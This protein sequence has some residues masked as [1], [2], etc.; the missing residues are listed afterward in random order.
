[1][2][3]NTAPSTKIKIMIVKKLNNLLILDFIFNI[4]LTNR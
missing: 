2:D 1:L 3:I 4:T